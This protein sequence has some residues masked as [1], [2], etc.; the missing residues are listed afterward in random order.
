MEEIKTPPIRVREQS[1]GNGLRELCNKYRKNRETWEIA[2]LAF[3]V[4]RDRQQ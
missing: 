2:S 3:D 4:E 1:E